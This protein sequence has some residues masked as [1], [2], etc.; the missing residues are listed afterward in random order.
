MI[1]KKIVL[2]ETVNRIIDTITKAGYEAYAVGGCIRDLLLGK[3]PGDYDITTQASP[4]TIK[5]LFRRTV[6]TGIEHGTV[7][8][9]IGSTGYEIT[10]YRIDGKSFAA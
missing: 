8:V 7:T 10:T 1:E 5:T 2:P 4:Q 3:E 6:D 9:M